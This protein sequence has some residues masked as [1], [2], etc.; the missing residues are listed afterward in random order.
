MFSSTTARVL[1]GLAVLLTGAA[2]LPA[3]ASAQF[4]WD[5]GTGTPPGLP[6]SYSSGTSSSAPDC[7]PSTWP[8]FPLCPL[9]AAT[10]MGTE[11]W[12]AE[13]Y[14]AVSA[15]LDQLAP[16]GDDF[17][18]GGYTGS[19]QSS[20]NPATQIATVYT[21]VYAD[22]HTVYYVYKGVFKLPCYRAGCGG[23]P[24]P[25]HVDSVT[26]LGMNLYNP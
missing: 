7:V 25:G 16:A 2:L 20:Y 15:D 23:T 11:I 19:A 5:Q 14:T 4:L 3:A 17:Y 18:A 26:Y 1:A 10:A 12:I 9:S 21:F 22:F 8:V 13:Y 24:T 6:N